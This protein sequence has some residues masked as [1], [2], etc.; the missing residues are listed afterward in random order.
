MKICSLV[1]V[2]ECRQSSSRGG[3]ESQDARV[4]LGSS[5]TYSQSF[6]VFEKHV[7]I[8]E[9]IVL[10]SWLL[11]TV[12]VLVKAEFHYAI[13]LASWFASWSATC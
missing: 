12:L 4:V 8:S 10:C 3:T 1:A 9:V 5:Q 13:Q 2:V 11:L 6:Y 7:K